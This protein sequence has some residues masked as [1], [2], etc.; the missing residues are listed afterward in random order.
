MG[1][2]QHVVSGAAGDRHGWVGDRRRWS[3]VTNAD[4]WW[5]MRGD[6]VDVAI[7]TGGASDA[8]AAKCTHHTSGKTAS[9]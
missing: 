1:G 5:P 8:A 6:R 2:G 7:D 4:E 9:M 3:V